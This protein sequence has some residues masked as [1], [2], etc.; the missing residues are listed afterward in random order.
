MQGGPNHGPRRN[1]LRTAKQFYTIPVLSIAGSGN[2]IFKH[3]RPI[4]TK[5]F[6]FRE[7]HHFEQFLAGSVP[8]AGTI[9]KSGPQ[10]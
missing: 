9:L 8:Q 3:P 2:E 7:Y 4:P 5:K 10:G 1:F 6:F